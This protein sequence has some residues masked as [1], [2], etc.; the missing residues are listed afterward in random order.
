MAGS[1]KSS[2]ILFYLP[3]RE[4]RL[5]RTLLNRLYEMEVVSSPNLSDY[6]R[7]ALRY[8]TAVILDKLEGSQ[9]GKD[10]PKK[11]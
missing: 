3:E 6:V 2:A 1:E 8:Y 10:G 7:D 5:Y 9:E 11:P 4:K